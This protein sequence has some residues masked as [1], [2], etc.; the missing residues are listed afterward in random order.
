[1]INARVHRTKESHSMAWHILFD[2]YR[3]NKMECLPTGRVDEMCAYMG[4]RVPHQDEMVL[5]KKHE[6]DELKTAA[7]Q[8]MRLPKGSVVID[9]TYLKTLHHGVV[10]RDAFQ[11]KSMIEKHGGLLLWQEQIDVLKSVLKLD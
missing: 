3:V 7:A 4:E 10:E 8:E 9:E 1:M 5:I 6:L 2:A 11:I